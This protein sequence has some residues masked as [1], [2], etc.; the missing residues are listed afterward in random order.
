MSNSSEYSA[1]AYYISFWYIWD[2]YSNKGTIFLELCVI[3]FLLSCRVMN[4]IK[5]DSEKVLTDDCKMI[6]LKVLE[7]F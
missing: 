4:N 7:S 5:I 6:E 2:S 3:T 1:I